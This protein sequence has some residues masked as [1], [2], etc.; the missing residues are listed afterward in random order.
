ME[1]PKRTLKDLIDQNPGWHIRPNGGL[2]LA[3]RREQI[4]T[5]R[6]RLAETI[7]TNDLDSLADKLA[8]QR[9]REAELRERVW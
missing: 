3:T 4:D 1:D 9:A 5:W 2:Y 6:T 7:I 8:E